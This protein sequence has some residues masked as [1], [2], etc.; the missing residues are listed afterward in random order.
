MGKSHGGCPFYTSRFLRENAE[1]IFTPYNYL[2]DAGIRESLGIDLNGNVVIIDEAHNIE[3]TARDSTSGTFTSFRLQEAINN[4]RRGG[5]IEPQWAH[6]YNILGSILENLVKWINSDERKVVVN[7]FE[8][9]VHKWNWTRIAQ[10]IKDIG[11][12]PTNISHIEGVFSEVKS[13][14]AMEKEKNKEKD[15]REYTREEYI[16]KQ[17]EPKCIIQTPSLD[18]LQSN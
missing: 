18:V 16:D 8:S 9:K 14:V 10:M 15:H 12:F 1:L 11:I 7:G 6:K 5:E 13:H 2:I 17:I 3:D 4:F